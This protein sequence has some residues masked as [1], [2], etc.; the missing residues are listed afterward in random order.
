[1]FLLRSMWN[2]HGLSILQKSSKRSLQSQTI[3][4]SHQVLG[5]SSSLPEALPTRTL[6]HTGQIHTG[7]GDCCN[8]LQ[9]HHSFAF[10]FVHQQFPPHTTSKWTA[11][12]SSF[13]HR[14]EGPLLATEFKS[15]IRNWLGREPGKMEN[16]MHTNHAHIK[17]KRGLITNAAG[18]KSSCLKSLGTCLAVWTRAAACPIFFRLLPLM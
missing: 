13:L 17:A 7:S 14:N 8:P 15:L 2:S 9:Q 5:S 6:T 11:P 16:Q 10:P 1:M 4:Y 12:A 3:C 18:S